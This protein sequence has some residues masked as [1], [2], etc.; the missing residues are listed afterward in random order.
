MILLA[1]IIA[2]SK[3]KMENDTYVPSSEETKD[4]FMMIVNVS[5]FGFVYIK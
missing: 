5:V 4:S 3:C 2:A 1:N